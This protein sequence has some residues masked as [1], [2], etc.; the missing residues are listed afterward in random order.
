MAFEFPFRAPVG[1][2][3]ANEAYF[4]VATNL[5]EAATYLRAGPL[6]EQDRFRLASGLQAMAESFENEHPPNGRTSGTYGP[7]GAS[8]P[9]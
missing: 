8:Q 1:S 5:V 2:D 6:T 9:H 4:A 3:K 7:Y